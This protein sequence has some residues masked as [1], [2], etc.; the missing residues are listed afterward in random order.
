MAIKNSINNK[1][2]DLTID[3]GASGD[4]F[5]QFN[6]NG[7]G[8]FRLGVDDDASDAFKISNGSALGTTDTFIM[9]ASG[10]RTMPL[11]PAFLATTITEQ[12]NVTGDGS[13]VTAVFGT[14]V[15]DQNADYDSTSTFT[16][17][18]S[19]RYSFTT[20]LSMKNA[21]VA[22]TNCSLSFITSNRSYVTVTQNPYSTSNGALLQ[23]KGTCFA[24]MDVGDT[25]YVQVNAG[26]GSKVI[27]L[28][29]TA[30]GY[31]YFSGYLVC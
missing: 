7:A 17:S 9:S 26:G 27:D 25:C 11:Q 23:L 21:L 30:A 6:I 2:Q 3:P 14:E 19:G 4:S 29:T 18:V 16:A 31:N 15:F 5:V 22:H 28:M 10:E 8:E 13:N 24:D 20:I 1:A 12:L